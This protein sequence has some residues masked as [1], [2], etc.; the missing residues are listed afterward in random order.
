RSH[1]RVT[2]HCCSLTTPTAWTFASS[3]TWRPRSGGRPLSPRAER[4]TLAEA[5]PTS[6]ASDI[7]TSSRS[8]GKLASCTARRS[9]HVHTPLPRRSP[10]R[11]YSYPVPSQ[12]SVVTA[13]RKGQYVRRIPIRFDVP[14][15][16]RHRL[17]LH[18]DRHRDQVRSQG[19]TRL[20]QA[21]H[22][23]ALGSR[24]RRPTRQARSRQT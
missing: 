8:F 13:L 23:G 21:R 18:H 10:V 15:L 14:Q 19:C 11:P 4:P 1:R 16:H 22:D 12:P 20:R 17:V 9:R 2:T 7:S 3:A 24:V 5:A 6:T